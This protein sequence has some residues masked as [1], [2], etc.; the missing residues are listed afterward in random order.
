MVP[1]LPRPPAALR[2]GTAPGNDAFLPQTFTNP[3]GLA[4]MLETPVET[5]LRLLLAAK[6]RRPQPPPAPTPSRISS[7]S[8]TGRVLWRV[9]KV[10]LGV[11]FVCCGA[12]SAAMLWVVFGFLLGPRHSDRDTP[13]SRIEATSDASLSRRGT[14]NAAE[15]SRPDVGSAAE[16]PIQPG[17][18]SAGATEQRKPAEETKTAEQAGSNQPQLIRA[19]TQTT[20]NQPQPIRTEMQDRGPAAGQQEISGELA[21]QRPGMQCNVDLC[22]ARYRS[23]N[24]ADC[25][26]EPYGGGPRTICELSKRPADAPRRHAGSWN[27][28]RDRGTSYYARSGWGCIAI[29][30]LRLGC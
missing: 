27:G 19:E 18:S 14:V 10:L 6:D 7:E 13:G 17:P 9:T 1:R 11:L 29:G 25:T 8:G 26:Y 3:G 23:F 21:D 4:V 16:A 12:L 20:S 15:P 22:A 30:P 28:A 2:S 24:A 5:R